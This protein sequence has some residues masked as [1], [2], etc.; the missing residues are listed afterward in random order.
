V[1]GDDD[2][3]PH[4]F[5]LDGLAVVSV[6]A[7]SEVAMD[8]RERGYVLLECPRVKL[9]EMYMELHKRELLIQLMDEP[10]SGVLYT[11]KELVN[12][13]ENRFFID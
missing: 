5:V 9:D 6:V 3:D 12:N 13:H 11:G 8:A 4:I 10:G 2:G 1:L 7:N